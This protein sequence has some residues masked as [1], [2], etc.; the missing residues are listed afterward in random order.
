MCSG[1]PGAQPGTSPI[2]PVGLCQRDGKGWGVYCK[3]LGGVAG[4]GLGSPDVPALWQRRRGLRSDRSRADPAPQ[5][6]G[7][8]EGT[9]PTGSRAVKDP[10]SVGPKPLGFNP[11]SRIL[12][13]SNADMP[14]VMVK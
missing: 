8:Q 13:L 9:D 5:G 12:H 7:D 10:D 1:R 4:V 3:C 14:G 6:C 11:F 2:G